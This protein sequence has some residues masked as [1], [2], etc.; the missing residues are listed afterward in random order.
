MRLTGVTSADIENLVVGLHVLCDDILEAR[1]SLVPVKLLL[2]LL[3]TVLPVFLL[4]VLSHVCSLLSLLI[5]IS[6]GS[7]QSVRPLI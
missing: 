3:V 2:V 6:I 7:D 5:T 4:S 1:V